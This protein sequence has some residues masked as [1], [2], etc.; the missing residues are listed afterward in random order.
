MTPLLSNPTFLLEF[1]CMNILSVCTLM[2][3]CIA[4]PRMAIAQESASDI[5]RRADLN[6]RGNSSYSNLSIKIVRP[7]WSREL[8]L[9]AWTKENKLALIRVDGPAKDK[10][11]VYL[12]R[13]KEVWYYLPAIER[14][15]KLPP[16][17]MSQS[18]MGTDFTN[19]DLVKEFSILDDYEHQLMGEEM[20]NDR[21]CYKLLLTPKPAA[22]VVWG[23]IITW[24]DKKDY[25]QLK[26]EYYDENG[27][28]VNRMN[29]SNIRK[30]GGR[31]LPAT[32]EMIPVDKPGQKTILEYR[33]IQFDQP[34]NENFFTVERMKLIQ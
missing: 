32:L 3:V 9:R 8:N 20:V 12:K 30:L 13:Q 7:S 17:M 5:I 15:I 22:A 25:L 33:D 24:I 1:N 11:T 6:M 21:N 27:K 28:L 34:L 26:A 29:G 18:W 2:A 14:N 16:S 23:K 31:W 10:G 4:G 19:D